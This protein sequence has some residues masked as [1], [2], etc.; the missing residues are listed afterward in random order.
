MTNKLF[1]WFIPYVSNGKL[2]SPVGSKKDPGSHFNSGS[3]DVQRL[4]HNAYL[5][6]HKAKCAIIATGIVFG[7]CCSGLGSLLIGCALFSLLGL[8]LAGCGFLVGGFVSSLA[9]ACEG[10]SSEDS[11]NTYK[12]F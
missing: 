10:S 11:N 7:C 1:Q 9:V 12:L 8:K 4:S 3:C 5:K 2:N 6:K